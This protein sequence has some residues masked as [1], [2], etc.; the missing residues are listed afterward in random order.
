MNGGVLFKHEH[1]IAAGTQH[2]INVLQNATNYYAAK[3]PPYDAVTP[4]FP[5]KSKLSLLIFHV[6]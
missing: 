4:I 5:L 3:L 2:F 1:A 6:P